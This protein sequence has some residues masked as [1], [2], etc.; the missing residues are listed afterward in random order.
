[1]CGMSSPNFAFARRLVQRSGASW[2]CS[3]V[4]ITPYCSGI[5]ATGR[6]FRRALVG[7]RAGLVPSRRRLIGEMIVPLGKDYGRG[8]ALTPAPR[9][10]PPL[11]IL[12]EA[13]TLWV[14]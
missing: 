2:T 5:L 13:G 10:Y 12:G 3:S 11:P 1:M 7:R 14:R 8:L 4:E 9:G 6:S